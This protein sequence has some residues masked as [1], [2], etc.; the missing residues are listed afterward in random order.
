MREIQGSREVRQR[1]P[2]DFSG[3]SCKGSLAFLQSAASSGH[4][5]LIYERG[6]RY[7]WLHGRSDSSCPATWS[8]RSS[9]PIAATSWTPTRVALRSPV[10][11]REIAGWPV[12]LKGRVRAQGRTGTI[13][14]IAR[15]GEG[16][17][18][19]VGSAPE[20]RHGGHSQRDEAVGTKAQRQAVVAR[21]PG[22]GI[23][24]GAIPHVARLAGERGPIP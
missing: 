12:R 20:V 14:W 6:A 3:E 21:R 7:L 18:P 17:G 1:R 8:S 10:E 15:G 2:G 19:R 16:S 24:Q 23:A 4:F 13:E 22:R 9:R 11:G 5:F